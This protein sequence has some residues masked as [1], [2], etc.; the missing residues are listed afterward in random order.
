MASLSCQYNRWQNAKQ[1][2]ITLG[3]YLNQQIGNIKE[4]LKSYGVDIDVDFYANSDIYNVDDITASENF[5]LY[6]VG[7][8]GE[9]YLVREVDG[10]HYYYVTDDKDDNRIIVSSWGDRYILDDTNTN[11]T[12]KLVLKK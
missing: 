11:W 7:T 12:S 5:S 4:Y 6:K 10:P 9:M 2:N 8:S 1:Y 3:I